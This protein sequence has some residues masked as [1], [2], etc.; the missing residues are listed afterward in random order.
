M[1]HDETSK[2]KDKQPSIFRRIAFAV[3]YIMFFGGFACGAILWVTGLFFEPAK[4]AS[5]TAVMVGIVG[6]ILSALVMVTKGSVNR[7]WLE[8]A[9]P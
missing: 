1:K 9:N 3:C 4:D 5:E 8:G 2:G 7:E 6:F